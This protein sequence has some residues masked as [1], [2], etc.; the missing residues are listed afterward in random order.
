MSFMGRRFS[1]NRFKRNNS[2]LATGFRCLLTMIIHTVI[3]Q[4]DL[5]DI[6]DELGVR[7]I[8][9]GYATLTML[10]G[11]VMPPE[12]VA[13]MA[14]A[15]QYFVN[16]DELQDKVGR[17]IAEWTHNEAAYISS[18]AAAGLVLSTAACIAGV[19]PILRE[20]LPFSD[21]L[22]NEVIVHRCGRVGYD[23]AIRQAGGR[24]VEI[25]DQ[26][27]ASVE[28]L[29]AAINERTAAVY[30]FYKQM[31]M[32]GQVPLESQITIAHRHAVPVIVD[33]AAQLPPVENLWWFT[34]QGVDLVIFSG[35]KGLCGPQSSGLILGRR[36]LVEACAFHACP[37][38]FIGRPMKAG[39]EEIIGLMAA[40]RWYLNLDHAKLLQAYEDM[41]G[42]VIAALENEVHLTA[43]RSFPSEAGQPM[44]RVEIQFDELACGITR[45]EL[46]QKLI[47][48]SPAISLAP[49]GTGGVFVN[50][51]TLRPGEERVIVNRLLEILNA[52]I[53]HQADL[54]SL[55]LAVDG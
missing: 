11:S 12:V 31:S 44:P 30:I 19:D 38:G 29:E 15:S 5:M 7:K 55:H 4:G 37:R 54:G 48:G 27:G 47:L 34:R 40:V 25:G 24:L 22:K 3:D 32:D 1:K 43:R 9:N 49:S 51:Q 23:F 8:I 20:R 33:A 13:A 10:G 50:P 46:L 39:K 18:G 17:K 6:Y 14:E 16:I 45:D 26:Q 53:A 28:D 41:V 42:W 36:D 21:G 2:R 35:G 52:S